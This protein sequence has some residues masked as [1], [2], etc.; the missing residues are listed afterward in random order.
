M[1]FGKAVRSSAV[2]RAPELASFLLQENVCPGCVLR[3]L[4]T[5]PSDLASPLPSAKA[6]NVSLHRSSSLEPPAGDDSNQAVQGGGTAVPNGREAVCPMCLGILQSLGAEF[7][8]GVVEGTLA[9]GGNEGSAQAATGQC[10]ENSKRGNDGAECLGSGGAVTAGQ[11]L[12]VVAE[13]KLVPG[14]GLCTVIKAGVQKSGQQFEDLA[15]ELV[16]PQLVQVRQHALW[17]HLQQAMPDLPLLRGGCSEAVLPV[18]DALKHALSTRLEQ[19]LGT[20]LDASS[21]VRC[22][23]SFSH[24]DNSAEVAAALSPAKQVARKRQKG[25]YGYWKRGGSPGENDDAARPEESLASVQK[26]LD[27]LS[28]Q[29]TRNRLPWP[30]AE[31]TAPCTVDVKCWRSPVFVGGRYLKLVRGLSQSP[32]L[33]DEE[34]VGKETSVQELLAAG[35]VGHFKVDDYKFSSAGREDIDVRMLGRG[36]P[37]VLELQNARVL[38]PPAAYAQM[39]AAVNSRPDKWVAVRDLALVDRSQVDLLREG[40]AEK[41]KEYAAIVWLPRPAT[42]ADVDKLNGMRDLV[43]QQRTPIRVLHRRSPLIR[44]RTIHSMRAERVAAK[45]HYLLLHLCT[46]AGTYVKEFVHGD[47]GRTHPNVGSILGC[48]AD[49]LQ[50]DVTNIRMDF[51]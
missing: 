28:P 26:A 42:Q 30:P 11:K 8:D 39:Q 46:Q 17:A 29:E 37:F 40:E 45:P 38:P 12:E 35:I 4:K 23:I 5:R 22:A 14:S 49:I 33:V 25:N 32:W 43:V 48:E 3:F 24:P 47:L 36:R 18:K 7:F 20:K 10:E 50:L 41:Q 27:G 2:A 9:G 31:A 13:E 34:R 1:D 6:S 51:P 44:P 19:T 16:L 15:L 21:S